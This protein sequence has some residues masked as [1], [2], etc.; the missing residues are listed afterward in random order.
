MIDR[1][2][3]LADIAARIGDVRFTPTNGHS[4]C[5]HQVC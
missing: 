5:L 1:H 3:S 2:G 4:Q